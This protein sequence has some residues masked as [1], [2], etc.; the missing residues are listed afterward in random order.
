M[1]NCLEKG[2]RE[3]KKLLKLEIIFST[4]DV[5]VLFF[6]FF[7]NRFLP[8]LFHVYRVYTWIII[9][10]G[11]WIF[12]GI[13]FIDDTM[14]KYRHDTWQKWRTKL[15]IAARHAHRISAHVDRNNQP[16]A[17]A[18]RSVD[19]FLIGAASGIADPINHRSI[20]RSRR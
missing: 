19:R 17:R 3:R 20:I 7:F 6:F 16:V 10:S 4:R 13:I 14:T 15:K 5:K 12:N 2:R 11:N 18:Y 8:F 1:Y 9:H